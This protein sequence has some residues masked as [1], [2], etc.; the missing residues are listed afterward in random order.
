MKTTATIALDYSGYEYED[1]CSDREI[2]A[3]KDIENGL[4]R[5]YDTMALIIPRSSMRFHRS[6]LPI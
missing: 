6:S 3:S 2:L 5:P 1:F 4:F